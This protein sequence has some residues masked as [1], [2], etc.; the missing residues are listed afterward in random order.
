M[1]G[2]V[3]GISNPNPILDTQVYDVELPDGSIVEYFANIIA[4]NMYAMCDP[5]GNQ[6]A[7]LEA[8]IDHKTD[9]N[10]IQKADGFTSGPGNKHRKKTTA[11]WHLCVEW[12]DGS[13]S[14]QRLA[15]LKE[16]YP[17]Q[18]AEYAVSAGI[19]D[20]PAFAWWVPYVFKRRDRIIAAVTKRCKKKDYKFG[21]FIPKTIKQCQEEDARNGNTLWMDAVAKEMKTI[22]VA[23]DV[24]KN[25]RKVPPGYEYMSG[26]I[27][28][29]V[30]H[31]TWERKIRWVA[32]GH[33]LDTP[34]ELTYSSVVSRD[35]VRI[36]LTMAALHDLKVK[37]SDISGAFLCS[38][39]RR[40]LY[41]VLG[42]EF[43]ELQGMKALVTRSIYGTGHACADYRS[44]VSDCMRHLGWTSCLADHDVYYMKCTRPDDGFEYYAY[45][46][47]Y[48]DDVLCIHHDAMSQIARLD[49]YFTMKKPYGDIDMY[50]GAKV[51]KCTLPNGVEAWGLSP[52]KYIRAAVD[53][54]KRYLAEHSLS[55]PKRASTPFAS[56]YDPDT[57]ASPLANDD[58]ASYMQQQIGV[59]RWIVELGRVD[60]ITEV[61]CISSM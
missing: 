22:M 20:E 23:F 28:A 57:D 5:E 27:V 7:L 36:A 61:S 59:L 38:K 44:A 16:S 52:A 40:K 46:L 51:R 30:K 2:N 24:L 54:V 4:E 33:K 9:G 32:D 12:K 39:N 31:S 55:L 43:G 18:V 48:V 25:G 42:P 26:H 49:K 41:T 34:K 47:L 14:W 10:A 60:I 6:Y 45:M 13:T 8:I 58:E 56:G 53:N 35:S 1:H 21:I 17:V 50:L 3:I 29:D 19:V 11:G 37:S 15:D